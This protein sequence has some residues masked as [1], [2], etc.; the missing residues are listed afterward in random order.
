[1]KKRW[2]GGTVSDIA[3]VLADLAST[4]WGS[5]TA[6]TSE[7]GERACGAST[8]GVQAAVGDAGQAVTGDLAFGKVVT[9]RVRDIGRY[10]RTVAEI[11][12]PDG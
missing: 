1:M 9:V 12:L 5:A 7:G 4:P 10:E 11:I 2:F 6:N 3:S 8:P